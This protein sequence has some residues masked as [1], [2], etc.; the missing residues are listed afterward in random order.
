MALDTEIGWILSS[1]E[2]NDTAIA[3]FHGT[4][5]SKFT[6]KALKARLGSQSASVCGNKAPL[7]E[8]YVL[9]LVDHVCGRVA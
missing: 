6:V 8:H 3:L 1:A 7:V 5:P 4:D 2:G 9:P